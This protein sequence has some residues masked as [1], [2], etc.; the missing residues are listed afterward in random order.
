MD[1]IYSQNGYSNFSLALYS[2]QLSLFCSV[3]KSATGVLT[4]LSRQKLN[5]ASPVV[6]GVELHIQQKA[7]FHSGLRNTG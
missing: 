1:D 2:L 6:N 4:L 5:V 3:K 7:G